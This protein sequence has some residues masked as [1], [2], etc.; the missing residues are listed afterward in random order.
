MNEDK[1]KLDEGKCEEI[2]AAE[3]K[4]LL[5]VWF[6]VIVYIVVVSLVSQ[7]YFYFDPYEITRMVMTRTPLAFVPL[8]IFLTGAYFLNKVM[9]GESL[10][11]I[12]QDARASAILYAA[13]FIAMA[14]AWLMS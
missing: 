13:L 2:E 12:A 1:I 7:R 10:Y 3:F 6:C 14:I 9:P 5:W 11:R 4:H 8:M